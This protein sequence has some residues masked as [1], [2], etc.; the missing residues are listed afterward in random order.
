M[1]LLKIQAYCPGQSGRSEPS[2]GRRKRSL[3]ETETEQSLQE[4]DVTNSTA[5][6][7][8]EVFNATGTIF[9]RDLS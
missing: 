5:I 2:F 1:C 6:I 8:N 7:E 4:A 9:L 3:N